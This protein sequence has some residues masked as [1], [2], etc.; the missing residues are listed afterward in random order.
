MRFDM[1]EYIDDNAIQRLIGDY[2]NPEGQLTGKVRYRPFGIILFDEI[3]KQT[4][5]SMI[6]YCKFWTMDE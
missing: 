5:Q 6:Y 4:R 1:N 2:Y 3:E